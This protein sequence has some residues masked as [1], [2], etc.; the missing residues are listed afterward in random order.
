MKVQVS[1]IIFLLTAVLAS[2]SQPSVRFL[3]KDN[4]LYDDPKSEPTSSAC[5]RFIREY[6]TFDSIPS[7]PNIGAAYF[8]E[9]NNAPKCGSCWNLT[10]TRSFMMTATSYVTIIDHGDALGEEFFTTTKNVLDVLGGGKA[11]EAG[12]IPDVLVAEVD[13]SYCKSSS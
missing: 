13:G 5:P 2:A 8:L 9:S 10:Y 7:Y 6:P 11:A 1:F 12:Y 4:T 3:V